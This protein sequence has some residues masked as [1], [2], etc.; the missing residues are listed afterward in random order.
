MQLMKF[1]LN[2]KQ[3]CGEQTK[4][5]PCPEWMI[6]RVLKTILLESSALLSQIITTFGYCKYKSKSEKCQSLR[7]D[8]LAKVTAITKEKITNYC[9]YC[10]WFLYCTV[11]FILLMMFCWFVL[12]F[13]FFPWDIRIL[14]STGSE[15]SCYIK[16][17]Q[18]IQKKIYRSY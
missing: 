15:H 12:L 8:F 18:Q 6:I 7:Y 2:K 9:H 4:S 13:S 3:L 5:I 14:H 16:T 10:Y 1:E 11:P 17:N